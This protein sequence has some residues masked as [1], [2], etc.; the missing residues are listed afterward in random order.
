MHSYK[1]NTLS[2]GCDRMVWGEGD[3]ETQ[4]IISDQGDKR[5]EAVECDKGTVGQKL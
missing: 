4:E 1:E 3:R 5:E 2:K